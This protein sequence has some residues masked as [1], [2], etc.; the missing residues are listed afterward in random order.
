MFIAAQKVNILLAS[1]IALFLMGCSKKDDNKPPLPAVVPSL[2]NYAHLDYLFTP[3]HFETGTEAAGIYIYAEAPDYHLVADADEGFTCTDD[4]ARAVLVY[5]RSDSFALKEETRNKTYLLLSFLTEMQAS[6]G[7]FYNFLLPGDLINKYHVNSVAGANWWS[8]RCFQALTEAAPLI[9]ENNPSLAALIDNAIRK[10]VA[11]IKSDL[12]TQTQSTKE[13]NGFTVPTWLP[14]GSATDQAATLLLGLINYCSHNDDAVIESY[15]TTIA[16]GIA[17]MQQGDADHF[18]YGCFMSWENQWHAYGN[19]Q[20]YALLKAGEFLDDH[21]YVEYAIAE[22]NGFYPWLFENGYKKEITFNKENSTVN[23]LTEQQ[24]DQIAYG[25]TPMVLAAAEAYRLTSDEKY[26]EI[27]GRAAAWYAGG[28]E[29]GL[30]IYSK[31]AGRCYDALTSASS[32]NKNSGAES[33]IEALLCLQNV[34]KY[35]S[36]KAVY[37]T[38][39]K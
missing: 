19:E 32:V 27:A 34:E 2:V 11:N 8:W 21:K 10:M 7:Y 17:M 36:I 39:S 4:V 9:R 18:P 16:D 35:P 13:T 25:V 12:V 20:A 28:N 23:I 1:I 33:T 24:F 31:D 15:I 14:L 26:A 29:A 22:I 3:V 37:S 6:N 5:L 38:Y 30:S